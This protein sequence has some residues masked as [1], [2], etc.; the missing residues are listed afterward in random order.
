ML[1]KEEKVKIIESLKDKFSRSKGVYITDFTGLKVGE[2]TELRKEFRQKNSEFEVAKN[3]LIKR[4]VKELNL[5]ELDQ[6]LA[7]PTGLG[8]AYSDPLANAKIL[9]EYFKKIEKPKVK[10]FWLEG[11][12]YR[13]DS[14]KIIASLPPK[15][16]LLQRILGG[17]NAPI[18]NFVFTLQGIFRNLIGSLDA[19]KEQKEKS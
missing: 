9:H 3:T 17:L 1:K 15:E 18:S 19:I 7:G 10:A 13:S 6:F 2:I 4:A 12:L 11:K 8:F 16:V 14:L 5:S